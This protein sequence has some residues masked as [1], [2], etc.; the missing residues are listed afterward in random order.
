MK[1]TNRK[2]LA[3]IK[4]KVMNGL[5]SQIGNKGKDEDEDYHCSLSILGSAVEEIEKQYGR[6]D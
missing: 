3:T 5:L 4:S 2:K 6:V 1:I